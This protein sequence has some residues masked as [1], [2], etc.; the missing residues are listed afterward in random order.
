MQKT[1]SR[2][3]IFVRLDAEKH[4]RLKNEAADLGVSLNDLC[5]IKLIGREEFRQIQTQKKQKNGQTT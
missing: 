3:V 5:L 2:K 1:T 4:V